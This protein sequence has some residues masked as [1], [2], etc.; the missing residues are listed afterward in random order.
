MRK[1]TA[2]DAERL[3][4]GSSSLYGQFHSLV[5]ASVGVARPGCEAR[6]LRFAAGALFISVVWGKDMPNQ[7]NVFLLTGPSLA[8]RVAM[9]PVA[10][11]VQHEC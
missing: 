5:P 10:A 8:A 4:G 7:R 11:R 9:S 2:S 6:G 1:L 3:A